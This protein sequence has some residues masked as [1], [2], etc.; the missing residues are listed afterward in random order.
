[1]VFQNTTL[2]YCRQLVVQ[3]EKMKIIINIVLSITFCSVFGQTPMTIVEY[4][5]NR[6]GYTWTPDSTLILDSISLF[7]FDNTGI[8]D[9]S[10]SFIIKVSGYE[11]TYRIDIQIHERFNEGILTTYTYAINREKK[12]KA[13]KEL[14]PEIKIKS[15]KVWKLQIKETIL[16][17]LLTD[18]LAYLMN[19]LNIDKLPIQE[20]LH[21]SIG[22]QVDGVSYT[23]AKTKNKQTKEYEIGQIYITEAPELNSLCPLKKIIESEIIDNKDYLVEYKNDGTIYNS[24]SST[25]FVYKT[26]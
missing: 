15:K 17:T 5:L 23:I 19:Q 7:P 25:I 16:P 1:M 20:S 18:T 10:E 13:D 6:K 11:Q 2:S 24:G 14:F 21:K 26:E 3:K 8:N 12:T 4:E 9:L 22:I